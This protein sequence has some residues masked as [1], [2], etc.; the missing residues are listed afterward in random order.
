MT[1]EEALKAYKDKFGEQYPLYCALG[2]SDAEIVE[3]IEICIA[4]NKPFEPE[5]G[6]AY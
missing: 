5:D 4:R 3:E 2:M 1:F 6:V